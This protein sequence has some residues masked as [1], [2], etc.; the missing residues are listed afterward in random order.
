MDPADPFRLFPYQ[1]IVDRPPIAWPNGAPVAVW[2]IPTNE[3]RM[4]AQ[5]TLGIIANQ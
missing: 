1:A 2:V 4:I 5:E 3:E